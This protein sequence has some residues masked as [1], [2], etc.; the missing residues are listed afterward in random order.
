MQILGSQSMNNASSAAS[1]SGTCGS[2]AADARRGRHLE[3]L[4]LGWSLT[5]AAVAIG[6]GLVAGSSA[7]IGFGADS[8]IETF[9]GGIL[10]WR[11]QSH[12]A[13]ER[14]ERIALKIVGASFFLIAAYVAIDAARDLILRQAPHA[15]LVGII[16][17]VVTLI[18]MPLLARA[19]H[20]VAARLES[21]ALRADSRQTSLCAWLSGIL[22]CGLLLNALL[23]WWWAD[24]V[25]A[26]IMVPIIAREGIEALRGET[27]TACH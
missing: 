18:V 11:L 6:A 23:G 13:D 10:L 9:S 21:R 27:C 25:A 1:C 4:S 22:L 2:R 3:Y 19:K 17:S 8:I 12:E 5:E 15:S 24:P 26:L 16:L 20:R 7:L 14:R